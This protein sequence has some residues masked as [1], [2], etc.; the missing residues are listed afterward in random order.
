MGVAARRAGRRCAEDRSA[1]ECVWWYMSA[2]RGSPLRGA[3]RV[4]MDVCMRP[5]HDHDPASASRVCAVG[6]S[7]P[8]GRA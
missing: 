4:T 7:R 1:R 6:L 2:G 5:M 3:R 8:R